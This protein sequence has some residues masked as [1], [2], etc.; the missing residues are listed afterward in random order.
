MQFKLCS[1]NLDVAE[2][3]LFLSEEVP[4]R[5]VAEIGLFSMK[6]NLQLGCGRDRSI[7]RRGSLQS[8]TVEASGTEVHNSGPRC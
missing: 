1:L 3:G 8:P 5:D 6:D 7:P 2:I 4:S